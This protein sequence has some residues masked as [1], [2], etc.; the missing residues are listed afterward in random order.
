MAVSAARTLS[1]ALLRPLLRLL[2][3][4]GVT[5]NHLT[6]ASFVIT[7]PAAV[8]VALHHVLAGLI[9]MGV[10]Q[11]MDGMD[12]AMARE[13]GLQSQAGARLDTALDR[14]CETVMFLAFA[15]GGYASWRLVLLA[16][17]AILLLTSIVEKSNVDPGAKR[18]ILYFAYF[19]PASWDPWRWAFLVIF[20]VNLAAYVVGLLV[21]DCKFQVK[22][23][24]LGG[25]LDTVASRAAVIEQA[26][27]RTAV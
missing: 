17:A 4:F 25:D 10:G 24:E 7:V 2:H 22:M 8:L 12:G 23:D 18:F 21:I 19:A 11:V 14:A 6:W 26:A 15:A 27:E 1:G 5:P 9:V 3:R 16:L 20:G 13:Y